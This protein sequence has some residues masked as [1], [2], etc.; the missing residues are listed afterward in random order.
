MR[1]V[2]FR[3]IYTVLPSFE[4]YYI[5]IVSWITCHFQIIIFFCIIILSL[6]VIITNLFKRKCLQLMLNNAIRIV[7]I[8][9]ALFNITYLYYLQFYSLV[10]YKHYNYIFCVNG[11][12][13]WLRMRNSTIIMMHAR[14]AAAYKLNSLACL[15]QYSS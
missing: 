10:V 7:I 14:A 3:Y 9:T 11:L 8:L 6:L 2:C 1:N 5:I 12:C 13:R 4:M 15:E